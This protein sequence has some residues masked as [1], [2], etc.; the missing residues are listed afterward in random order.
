MNQTVI[1]LGLDVDDTHYRGSAVN[2]HAGEVV[3]FKC[4][5]TFEGRRYQHED[6]DRCFP[7]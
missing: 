4:R 3:D 5:A 6:L 2:K 1:H 7:S